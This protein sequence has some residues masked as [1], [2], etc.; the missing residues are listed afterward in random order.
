MGSHPTPSESPNRHQQIRIQ[1]QERRTHDHCQI[2][3]QASGKG[4]QSDL[5]CQ[6]PRYLCASCQLASI[7]ILLAIAAIFS[8]EIHQMDVVTAFLAGDLEEEIYMEQLEGFKVGSKEDDLICR[9]RKSIYGLKQVPRVWNQQ[10]RHFLKS[11]SF[12]QLYSDPCVYINKTMNIIIV[13]WVGDLIIFGMDMARINDFKAQLSAEYEMKDLGELKYFLGIQVHRDRERKI[14]H[15]SQ[16]TTARFS[17][18]MTWKAA[19]R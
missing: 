3:G 12:D 10:L 2:E 17:N 11:I 15:I 16:A 6:L 19:N 13:I 4:I 14:I 7:R 9:L 5:W 1:A 8:L 18:D